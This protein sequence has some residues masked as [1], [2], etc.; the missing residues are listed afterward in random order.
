MN[1]I[2]LFLCTLWCCTTFA[3]T[4]YPLTLTING[5]PITI[6]KKPRRII[7]MA[8]NMTE[9]LFALGAGNKVVGR[10]HYCDYPTE[11]KSI[12]SIGHLYAPNIEKI[13]SLKPDLV[14]AATHYNPKSLRHIRSAGIPVIEQPTP[15]SIKTIYAYILRAGVI[16]DHN[17]EAD[18]LVTTLK[19]T[20]NAIQQLHPKITH[21]PL[22]YYSVATGRS[23]EFTAGGD[24]YLSDLITH[25]GGTNVAQK[26]TGW[27]YNL[28]M[29]LVNNPEIILG[30]SLIYKTMMS[31]P[32]Y[33][34]LKAIQQKNFIIIDETIFTRM[35]PRLITSGADQLFK[36]FQPTLYKE[37]HN[38]KPVKT[39]SP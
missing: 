35:S 2:L 21:K 37:L 22:V 9:L 11:A 12:E 30:D 6:A 26:V 4:H 34:N 18:S 19:S 15:T 14:I 8:P 10:S 29:L 31:H 7:S 23:G 33:Q 38:D 5:K 1:R 20:M 36:I 13:I 39:I 28:E 25:C 24:T 3:Q 16:I 27:Q 17:S 32:N